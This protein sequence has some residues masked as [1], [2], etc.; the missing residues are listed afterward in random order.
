MVTLLAKIQDYRKRSLHLQKILRK[1]PLSWGRYQSEFNQELNG[2][3]RDLM[4]YVQDMESKGKAANVE[5][6]KLLFVEKLRKYFLHGDYV[7]HSL[8]K[9]RG[10]AG[11]YQII[12]A[13]YRNNPK[14]TGYDRLFDNYF[15]MS[16]VSIAV[17]N[18]KDDFKKIIHNVAANKK[19]PIRILNLASGPA[20]EIDE[21]LRSPLLKDRDIFF[22]CVEQDQGAIDFAKCLID[23]PQRTRFI[24]Q[25]VSRIALKSN[26]ESTMKDRYDL[27]YSTGL[28]DYLDYRLS[29]R[30]IRNLKRLLK[31][32]GVLAISDVRDR[33]TNPSIFFMEWVGDWNLLYRDDDTFRG[34]FVDAGFEEKNLLSLYEQQGLFQYVIA[35]DSSVQAAGLCNQTYCVDYG[36]IEA[37]PSAAA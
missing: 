9:P 21:A 20:R 23:D 14:T 13:I 10:Y 36:A 4:V 8:K 3:F 37:F 1:E 7:N 26:I 5:R 28:F 6:L 29:L 16:A 25:N 11:D 15:Q 35:S 27:I 12:D 34:I 32:D 24:K 31:S 22:D 17:R 2:V 30:L 19:G 33:F 18:R